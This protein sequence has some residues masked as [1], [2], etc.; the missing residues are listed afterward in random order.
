MTEETQPGPPADKNELTCRELVEIV[1]D[2][3]EGA[4]EPDARAR[5]EHH[6]SG[7]DGCTNYLSQ[8]RETVRLTGRLR[9]HDLEPAARETL[10]E[11]FRDWRRP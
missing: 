5:V 2:Y 7:C 4:L 9:E 8:M 3:L 1:T 11:A 6:L 10:L